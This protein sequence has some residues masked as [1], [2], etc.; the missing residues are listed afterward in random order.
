MLCDRDARIH[1]FAEGE[2][3]CECGKLSEE[4]FIPP[5]TESSSGVL[6]GDKTGKLN[7]LLVRDGPLLQRWATLLTKGAAERGDRNWMKAS[8]TDDLERF[9]ES[10]ARHFEQWLNDE[11]DEDHAAA[12]V[13]N[14]NG[15]E[16]T[17]EILD[18]PRWVSPLR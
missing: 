12:V 4:D 15:V 6:R 8:S 11:T 13:F 3:F 16:Y 9:K 5:L 14:M 1:R 10:A 2:R 17:K 7:F 18:A